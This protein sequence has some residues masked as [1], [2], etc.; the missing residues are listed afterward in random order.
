MSTDKAPTEAKLLVWRHLQ[1]I[2]QEPPDADI[3]ERGQSTGPSLIRT[4]FS[5]PSW[6]PTPLSCLPGPLAYKFSFNPHHHSIRHVLLLAPFY[7]GGNRLKEVSN[8]SSVC[9]GENVKL[10]RSL[11]HISGPGQG[12]WRINSFSKSCICSHSQEAWSFP[13]S[14]RATDRSW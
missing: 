4:H 12:M 2:T 3:K 1:L 10:A 13:N 9:R 11:T 6:W 7:G 14:Q 5:L 8:R